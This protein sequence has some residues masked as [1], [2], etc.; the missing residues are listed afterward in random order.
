MGRATGEAAKKKS[1]RIVAMLLLAITIITN[2]VEHKYSPTT[3]KDNNIPFE[4][5]KFG[6]LTLQMR[7][8]TAQ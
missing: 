2:L 3:I 8:E 6:L 1:L 4:L 5:G 7:L